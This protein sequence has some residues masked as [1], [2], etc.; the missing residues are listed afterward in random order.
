[1]SGY[2]ARLVALGLCAFLS[3][4]CSGEREAVLQPPQAGGANADAKLTWGNIHEIPGTAVMRMDLLDGSGYGLSSQGPETRNVLFLD[5][6]EKFG[7]WLLPDSR[8]YFAIEIALR[9]Y[10]DDGR[11]RYTPFGTAVLVKEVGQPFGKGTGRLLVFDTVGRTVEW[12]GEGIRWLHAA[13]VSPSGDWVILFERNQ[14]FVTAVVDG[15]SLKLKQEQAF[16]IP[17]LE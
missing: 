4:G 16:D 13:S 15:Q 1:M 9:P 17:P 6:A 10:D 14:Q 2:F 5:P 12:L 3:G 11:R 8:H 7:R